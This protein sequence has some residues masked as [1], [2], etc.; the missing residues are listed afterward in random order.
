MTLSNYFQDLTVTIL[1][2]I[3]VERCGAFEFS[4]GLN[5]TQPKQNSRQTQSH[6]TI[7]LIIRE[8]FVAGPKSGPQSNRQKSNG[9]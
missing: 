9:F 6:S 1:E 4:A 3:T 8:Q 5:S 7:W 2:G